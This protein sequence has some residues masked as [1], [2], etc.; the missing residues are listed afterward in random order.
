MPPSPLRYLAIR[1][2]LKWHIMEIRTIST[3]YDVKRKGSLWYPLVSTIGKG[4]PT[5]ANIYYFTHLKKRSI[6]QDKG[7]GPELESLVFSPLNEL[8]PV[9]YLLVR[10]GDIE[11]HANPVWACPD[12]FTANL[13]MFLTGGKRK[14]QGKLLSDTEG[15]ACFDKH[16]ASTYIVDEIPVGMTLSGVIYHHEEGFP[17][18]FPSSFMTAFIWEH[19]E[20]VLHHFGLSPLYREQYLMTKPIVSPI[21]KVNILVLSLELVCC[22]TTHNYPLWLCYNNHA[23][24]T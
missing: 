24:S 2:A 20:T 16:S 18:M 9:C 5:N 7:S 19:S 15:H 6:E 8:L 1:N 12:N 11:F 4:Y 22:E 14:T 3:T 13:D 21:K 17:V 23:K 10:S